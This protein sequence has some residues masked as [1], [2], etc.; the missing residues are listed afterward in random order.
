[1]PDAS[2]AASLYVSSVIVNCG[3]EGITVHHV[4]C[5]LDGLRC[6]SDL[7]FD[8]VSFGDMLGL[9][10]GGIMLCLVRTSVMR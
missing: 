7:I 4:I 3:V 1:M 10:S 9:I 8:Q 2:F 5:R 6:G